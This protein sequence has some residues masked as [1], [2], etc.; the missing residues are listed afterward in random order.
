MFVPTSSVDAVALPQSHDTHTHWHTHRSPL[1]RPTEVKREPLL[2][3]VPLLQ[4]S[5]RS[6]SL[7]RRGRHVIGLEVDAYRSH[8]TK[9]KPPPR[10]F[11]TTGFILGNHAHRGSV[12]YV[13]LDARILCRRLW[14][15]WPV[16]PER[17]PPHG[18]PGAAQVGSKLTDDSA[19][20]LAMR[21]WGTSQPLVSCSAYVSVRQR[22]HAARR[23]SGPP[24][25]AQRMHAPPSARSLESWR[26]DR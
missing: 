6:F 3:H 14:S 21:L 20:H 24:R 10:I 2:P 11:N 17:H 19:F 4:S 26:G 8:M 18:S 23:S 1:P 16:D 7:I 12:Y 25:R 22:H 5:T 13:G 15:P 9:P